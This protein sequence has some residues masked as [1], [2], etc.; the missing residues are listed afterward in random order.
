MI[1]V[2]PAYVAN[3]FE[4]L[5]VNSSCFRFCR[6]YCS[7]SVGKQRAFVNVIDCMVTLNKTS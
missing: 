1:A 2:Y 3:E 6:L 5:L 7:S 4:A